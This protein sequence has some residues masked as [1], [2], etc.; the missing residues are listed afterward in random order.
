VSDLRFWQNAVA[1]LYSVR[2]IPQNFLINPQGKIIAKNLFGERL[3]NR[4]S[5][6][7]SGAGEPAPVK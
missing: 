1:Q 2:T 7:F 5:K 4:F 6:I 3:A